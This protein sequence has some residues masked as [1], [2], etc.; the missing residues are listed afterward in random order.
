M[1]LLLFL[2]AC[3][4]PTCTLQV[5]DAHQSC[6]VDEDCA[7]VATDC[8]QGCTCAAVNVEHLESYQGKTAPDCGEGCSAEPCTQDCTETLDVLCRRNVCETLG[9]GTDTFAG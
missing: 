2:F 6:E 1:S 3:E 9:S 4:S 5:Q 7:L 8:A